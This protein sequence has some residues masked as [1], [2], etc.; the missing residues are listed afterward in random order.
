M[1]V[2]SI[3]KILA[4]YDTPTWESYVMGLLPTLRSIN[5]NYYHSINGLLGMYRDGALT[6]T[7]VRKT[8]L[9]ICNEIN[10]RPV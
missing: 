9:D 1:E 6:Q 5:I 7:T 3:F 8:V 10:E 2:N 4:L